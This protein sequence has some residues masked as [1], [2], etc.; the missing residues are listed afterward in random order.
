MR[1]EKGDRAVAAVAKSREEE[2]EEEEEG[3][4]VAV[5]ENR[6]E[7][8]QVHVTLLLLLLNPPPPPPPPPLVEVTHPALLQAPNP[9]FQ[10]TQLG[11]VPSVGHVYVATLPSYPGPH[12]MGRECRV[13]KPQSTARV[14]V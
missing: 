5:R 7:A 6:D 8:V 4:A 11:N 9:P 1:E 14:K 10:A 3:M 12:I 13:S 2:E